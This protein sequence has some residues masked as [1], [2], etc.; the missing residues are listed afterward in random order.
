MIKNENAESLE[1]LLLDYHLKRLDPS[2]AETVEDAV[3]HSPELATQSQSLRQVLSL[4]DRY[5]APEPPADL[6]DKVLARIN[7]QSTV[8]PFPQPAPSLPG[9]ANRELASSPVLSL[10][11]VIAIAACITLFIGVFVP[12]YY[13]A[14]SIA[15][16]Q[17]CR[18]NMAKIFGGMAAYA[19]A[20]G[21]SLPFVDYVENGFWMPQ[22]IKGLPRASNTRPIY[23]LVREKYVQDPR[24]FI[25]P[26]ATDARPMLADDYREFHDFAEQANN[27]YSFV[28]SNCKE[29][30]KM[31]NLRG[32]DGHMAL[33][34]DRN[35]LFDGRAVHRVNPYDEETFNSPTHDN[36][37]GQN[38]LYATGQAG[39]FTT[40]LVGV[41]RDNIYRAGQIVRYLGNETPSYPTDSFIIP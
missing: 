6:A 4:L 3:A 31:E 9:G 12:G 38:V 16:R 13:R 22:R 26:S 11:E 28:F 33:A 34:G 7:G 21:D 20:N 18:T 2:Q 1:S 15:S 14:R 37:A 40:P 36:G 35:P 30:A 27:S 41:N 25:C 8:I 5:E 24:A 17:Q 19:S 39:W 10:R 23:L 29:P 32:D